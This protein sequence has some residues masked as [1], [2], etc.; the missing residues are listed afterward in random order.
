MVLR[1]N[2]K[3]GVLAL[4]FLPRLFSEFGSSLTIGRASRGKDKKIGSLKKS[5]MNTIAKLK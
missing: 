5:Q 2:D 4:E 3:N 1:T